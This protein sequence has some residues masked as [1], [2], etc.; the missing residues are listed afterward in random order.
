MT[1]FDC[2]VIAVIA[3]S[4]L[5]AFF[6]GVMCELIGLVAW[7]VGFVAGDRLRAVARRAAAGVRPTIPLRYV[8]AF[9]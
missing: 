8:L 6:R 4:T 5:I 7:I 2:R 3:L 9:V 1:G